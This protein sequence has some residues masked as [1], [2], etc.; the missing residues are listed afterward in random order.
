MQNP[1]ALEK[2]VLPL[3]ALLL[4]RTVVKT[5][6]KLPH[7]PQID[8]PSQP[9]LA[10]SAR[11]QGGQPTVLAASPHCLGSGDSVHPLANGSA[12]PAGRQPGLLRPLHAL[13]RAHA[14]CGSAAAAP[15]FAARRPVGA[16]AAAGGERQP[17]RAGLNQQPQRPA[18][19]SPIAAA[20]RLAAGS[21]R[22]PLTAAIG[23]LLR[24]L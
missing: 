1:A 13:G 10:T 6:C 23:A 22:P 8:S 20:I 2:R 9:L 17:R 18:P 16:A 7:W 14:A 5:I 21:A 3:A 24:F 4:D 12:R 15:S 19:R 11:A